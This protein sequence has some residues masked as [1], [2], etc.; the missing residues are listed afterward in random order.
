MALLKQEAGDTKG[1]QN[2]LAQ[3][4]ERS[5]DKDDPRLDQVA[6]DWGLAPLR[7]LKVPSALS[8]KPKPA[9][10]GPPKP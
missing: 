10:S 4:R 8:P 2:F 5:P 9:D 3:A 6:T 1:A 7:A